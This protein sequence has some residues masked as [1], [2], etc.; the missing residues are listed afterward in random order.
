MGVKAVNEASS[1]TP[2]TWSSTTTGSTIRLPGGI[3]P[4]PE[5]MLM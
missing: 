3:G 2:S 5:E 1:M 4:R